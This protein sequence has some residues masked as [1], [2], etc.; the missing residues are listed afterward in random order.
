MSKRLEDKVVIITGG[1]SGI[2]K[3]MV[4]VFANEGAKVVFAD[5][6]EKEGK[7]FEEK[8]KKDGK[9]VKFC[10]TDV[11][12]EEDLNNLVKTTVD[13]YGKIDVLC[14]NAGRSVP[15]KLE[16]MEAEKHLDPIF[17]LNIRAYFI[18]TRKVLKYM[19]EAKKGAIVNTASLAGI[20]GLVDYSS[21]CATKGAVI[22]FTKA[23]A[24]EFAER[25]IRFNAIAPGL[26]NT[27]LIPPGCDFEKLVLP[28]IPMKRAASPEEIAN[29]ALFLASD[30]SSYCTG[31][32]LVVD[33]GKSIL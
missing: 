18:L 12:K 23:G 9:E 3:G 22:Q 6:K 11:T 24:V 4:K 29:A 31:T 7:V 27:E 5:I 16:E 25:N 19:I 2:G 14:N 30:E 21:Y 20:E 10:L 28:D 26:T 33:G 1:S 8:L 17:D 32:I 15:F 13:A